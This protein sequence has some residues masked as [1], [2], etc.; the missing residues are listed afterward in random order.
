MEI[1]HQVIGG[2]GKTS[3]PKLHTGFLLKTHIVRCIQIDII[4]DFVAEG[5]GVCNENTEMAE[6][7]CIETSAVVSI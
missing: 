3:A 5:K 7:A 1:V 2:L 4:A 6:S